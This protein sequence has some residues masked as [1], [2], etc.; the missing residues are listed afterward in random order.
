MPENNLIIDPGGRLDKKGQMN[1]QFTNFCAISILV[2]RYSCVGRIELTSGIRNFCL[3]PS[4]IRILEAS[5]I[6]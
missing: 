3:Y 1:F 5:W 2:L 4:M 6:F